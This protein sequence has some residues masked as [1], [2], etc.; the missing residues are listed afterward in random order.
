M[1]I[2]FDICEHGDVIKDAHHGCPNFPSAHSDVTLA[3]KNI[4]LARDLQGTATADRLPDREAMR[5]SSLW[6]SPLATSSWPEQSVTRS[7]QYFVAYAD[8]YLAFWED[9]WKR[10]CCTS[11]NAKELKK[12][13]LGR[14]N[15]I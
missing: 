12:L 4:I 15:N 3:Q 11:Y 8:L 13:K 9:I 1:P 14:H 2:S 5:E 7:L 10:K 6:L